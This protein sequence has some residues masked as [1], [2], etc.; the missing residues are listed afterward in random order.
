MTH[1]TENDLLELGFRVGATGH[2]Y[3]RDSTSDGVW[4]YVQLDPPHYDK[5][6]G[7]VYA[8]ENHQDGDLWLLL[9]HVELSDKQEL[10]ELLGAV[11]TLPDTPSK[12]GEVSLRYRS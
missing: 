12:I 2:T 10:L 7:R 1:I 5:V 4:Y 11:G 9:D 8:V 6:R 3:R